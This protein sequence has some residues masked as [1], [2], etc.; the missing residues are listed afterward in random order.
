MS[1]SPFTLIFEKAGIL[2]AASVMNAVILTAILSA[3]NSGLYASSRMLYS[4]AVSG[5]APKIFAK[6]NSRGVPMPAL[7]ATT[8]IGGFAFLTSLIGDGTAYVWLI[9]VSG[10]AGF[11]VWAGIAW[12]HYRFRRAFKLQGHDVS[13]LPFRSKLY[14]LG[15]IVALVMVLVVIAGQ[16]LEVWQGRADWLTVFSTYVGLLAFLALWVGHKLITKSPGVKLTDADLSRTI[17]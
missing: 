1:V 17:D 11:I 3:G 14:P 7:L 16:N 6:V 8:A 2:G 13:E 4:M 9:T 12:S 15:P 10:L 5:K